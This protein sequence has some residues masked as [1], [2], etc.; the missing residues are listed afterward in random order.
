LK[1]SDAM[2]RAGKPHQVLPLS[3][4]THMVPE[5]LV[6]E[7]LYERIAQFFKETL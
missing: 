7:R 3:N 2:F 6:T 1:L 5:P 4:F